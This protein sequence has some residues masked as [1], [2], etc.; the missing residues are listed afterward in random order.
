MD[1]FISLSTNEK[2][3]LYPTINNRNPSNGLW[4]QETIKQNQAHQINKGSS[5]IIVGV[6]DT[7]VDYLHNDLKENIFFNEKEIPANGIDDDNNG[8]IDDYYGFNFFSNYG[9]GMDDNGHGTHCAG[10]IAS[11]GDLIGVAPNVKI[12]PLKFLNNYGSG[13]IAK[14]IDAITYAVDMGAKILTNSYGNPNSNQAF[15]EAVNYA[16]E[17]GVLFFAAA[18]NAK[19]DND[20]RGGIPS[21]L[22]LG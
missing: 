2:I 22:P 16:K 13:D 3:K 12:L 14:A 19:N 7:G 21:Q 8:K 10:I 4:W 20:G 18:G 5:D 17:N 1:G 6:L 11:N 9:S 15:L